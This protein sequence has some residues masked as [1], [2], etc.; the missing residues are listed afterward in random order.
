[1]RTVNVS[2]DK[3]AGRFTALGRHPGKTIDINAPALPSDEGRRPTGF[4]ATELL[5]AAAGSCAAWDVVEILRKRR[6]DINSLD[7]AVDGDQDKDPPWTYR[8][9]SLHF[10]ISGEGLKVPVLARVIRLSIVRYCSVITTV[11]GAATIEATVELVAPDGTTT[12]R[13]PIELAIPAIPPP[14]FREPVVDEDEPIATD[15]A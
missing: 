7:V 15:D 2:W 9:V 11:A 6:H 3:E 10:R 8:R 1:M 5:L 4:S 14:D 12:G 13:V